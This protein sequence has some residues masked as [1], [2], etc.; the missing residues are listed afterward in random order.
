MSNA[1][2]VLERALVSR[3]WHSVDSLMNYVLQN[4]EDVTKEELGKLLKLADIQLKNNVPL[5]EYMTTN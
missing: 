2:Y 3:K 5:K 1:I 4:S